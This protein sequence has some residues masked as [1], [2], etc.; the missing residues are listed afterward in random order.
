MCIRT[1][2]IDIIGLAETHLK[3]NEQIKLDGYRWY[4]HNRQKIH[5]KAKS[6][7]GGVGVLIKEKVLKEFEADILDNE[8]DG[9]LWM[10]FKH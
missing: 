8:T 2:D 4:V 5:R 1:A 10:K 3:G 9:I 6:G 7:S